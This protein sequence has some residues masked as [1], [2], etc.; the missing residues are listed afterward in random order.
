VIRWN[1]LR[2][3]SLSIVGTGP[4]T[5]ERSENMFDG[6]YSYELAMEKIEHGIKAH[7]HHRLVM[8]LHSVRKGQRRGM[9]ARTTAFVLALFR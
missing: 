8:Q 3:Y 4:T 1:A 2:A 6:D 7:E 5:K 9:V